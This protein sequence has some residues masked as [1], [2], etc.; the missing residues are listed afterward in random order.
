MNQTSVSPGD[1]EGLW[2]QPA[3]DALRARQ[4]LLRSPLVSAS[5]GLV[6][7][8]FFCVPFLALDL[9]R[10]L[11]P[12]IGGYRIR[13]KPGG[14][15]WRW[16][17][18]LGRILVNY[19]VGVV[20]ATALL[21]SLRSFDMPE[22]APSCLLLLRQIILALLLFDSLFFLIHITMH[23]I[24]WLYQH[25]HRTHHLNYDMFALIAQDAS[26]PEL[27]SLQFLAIISTVIVGC[28]PMSELL[29]H[30]LNS[31][32]AVEDHC[33]YDLPFSFHRVIPIFGGARF[34]QA[35]HEKLKGNYA[36][37]FKHW[38]WLFGTML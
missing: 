38:D 2:L 5:F 34:H 25:V 33:G 35:H 37:Y 8:L 26:I 28:H 31:W 10:R 18:S 19:L 9:L 22:L 17:G 12:G 24:N 14:S 13:D 11:H 21:L 27:L 36:P 20:P 29:F 32:L 15:L 4:Q 30:L 1:A 23:K 6:L 7:H 3:Y 16:V